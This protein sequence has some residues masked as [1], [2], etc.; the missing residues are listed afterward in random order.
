[1]PSSERAPVSLATS[2]QM[3]RSPESPPDR[4]DNRQVRPRLLGPNDIDRV[5]DDAIDVPRREP[6]D[7]R[8]IVG[9]VGQN[10]VAGIVSGA[11]DR[12]AELA[13]IGVERDALQP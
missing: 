1:M 7:D 13:V 4:Y 2:S 6:A 10:F 12:R 9:G 11:D 3:Q 5:G 8:G